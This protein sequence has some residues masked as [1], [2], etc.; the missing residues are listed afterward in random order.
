MGVAGKRTAVRRPVYS[1][2]RHTLSTATGMGLAVTLEAA[3]PSAKLGVK[4]RMAKLF[5]VFLCHS[6]RK[7]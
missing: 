1:Q 7:P 6:S 2:M 4:G 5:R 3:K